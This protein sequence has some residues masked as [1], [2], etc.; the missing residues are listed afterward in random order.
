MSDRESILAAIE[1]RRRSA[2]PS[3]P[4]PASASNS[5]VRTSAKPIP[6]TI[7]YS[8][9]DKDHDRRQEFRRLVDPGI[10]R[11][12]SREVAY[13]AIKVRSCHLVSVISHAKWANG[14]SKTL[15]MLAK[16][17][18]DHPDEQKYHRF[19]PTNTAIRRKIVDPKGTL[20]YAVE[21]RRTCHRSSYPIAHLTPFVYPARIQTRGKLELFVSSVPLGLI[22]KAGH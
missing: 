17:I 19:K 4:V 8:D 21:A 10:T 22:L 14:V 13:E 9:F 16:N 18:I 20:E 2:A 7:N 12:N 1:S 11:S 15:A 6:K 3:S 5:S